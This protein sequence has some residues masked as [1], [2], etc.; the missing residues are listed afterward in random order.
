LIIPEIEIE[1]SDGIEDGTEL[2]TVKIGPLETK[3]PDFQRDEIV[4]DEPFKIE[5]LYHE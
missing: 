4:T 1:L 3:T 5:I 2:E